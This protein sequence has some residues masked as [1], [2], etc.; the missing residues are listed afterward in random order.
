MGATLTIPEPYVYQIIVS[1]RSR[2]VERDLRANSTALSH[3]LYQTLPCVELVEA[4]IHECACIPPLGCVVYKS[5]Y[6]LPKPLQG[7]AGDFIRS[8]TTLDGRHEISMT[9]WE[10]A[11][12]QVGNRYTSSRAMAYIRNK[13][14]YL[15]MNPLETEVVAVTA[16]FED[17]IEAYSFPSYCDGEEGNDCT[18]IL[19][20]P[21]PADE[22]L[23]DAIVASAKTE[24]MGMTPNY[25]PTGTRRQRDED[26]ANGYEDLL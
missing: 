24:I 11:K 7:M 8:I 22:R 5:K 10:A 2:I 12:F 13:Y 19:D 14:L 17:P 25:R 21:F 3:F 9:T 15:T 6:P 16:L 1:N 23:L 20:R 18:P 26:R 4:P